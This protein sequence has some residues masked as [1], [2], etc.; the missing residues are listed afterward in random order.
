MAS[1]SASSA[2]RRLNIIII[3]NFSTFQLRLWL[4]NY[5]KRVKAIICARKTLRDICK[6]TKHTWN[7]EYN[8]FH[9]AL[10]FSICV[11][12]NFK[13]FLSFIISGQLCCVFE[14]HLK[15]QLNK[16]KVSK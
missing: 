10:Q 3:I 8:L 14:Q 2:H 5:T 11:G 6:I 9:F 1:N 7:V 4:I 12:W 16:A 13:C 15:R